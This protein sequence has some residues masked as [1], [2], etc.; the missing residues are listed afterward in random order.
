MKSFVQEKTLYL[1]HNRIGFK[2]DSCAGYSLIQQHLDN[3]F[4]VDALTQGIG[5]T[6]SSGKKYKL[7]NFSQLKAAL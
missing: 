2:E 4:F 1:G 5:A 6:P 3:S 7:H